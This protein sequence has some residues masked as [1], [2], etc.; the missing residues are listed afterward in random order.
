MIVLF[1]LYSTY[2]DSGIHR[3]LLHEGNFFR[4][5][6]SKQKN[7]FSI[8][9]CR[10]AISIIFGSCRSTRQGFGS[11]MPRA[12]LGCSIGSRFPAF[13]LSTGLW[14]TG[15]LPRQRCGW[16]SLR[17]TAAL[18]EIADIAQ[19]R[20]KRPRRIDGAPF[21]HF[22]QQRFQRSAFAEGEEFKLYAKPFGRAC[23]RCFDPL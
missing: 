16:A 5:C 19:Q 18:P 15:L 2:C 8:K 11:S 14:L 1:F 21:G 12:A 23:R 9:L 6:K 17:S 10:S 4:L 3:L 20:N 13:R 7:A 22:V